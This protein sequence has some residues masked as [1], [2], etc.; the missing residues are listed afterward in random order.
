MTDEATLVRRPNNMLTVAANYRIDKQTTIFGNLNAVEE[1]FD[2]GSKVISSYEVINLGMD[3]SVSS[4][5]SLSLKINNITDE[6]Y[7]QIAG[8]PGLPRQAFLGLNYKF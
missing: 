3:Y 5:S 2:A 1:H 6:N 4:S 8:Y 7:E